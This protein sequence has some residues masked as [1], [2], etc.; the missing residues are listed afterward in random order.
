MGPNIG[1]LPVDAARE[2]QSFLRNFRLHDL[3]STHTPGHNIS[4]LNVLL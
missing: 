2:K 4:F 1:K 3:G